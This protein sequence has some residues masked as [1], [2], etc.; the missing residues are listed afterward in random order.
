[1]VKADWPSVWL[2][3]GTIRPLT[4]AIQQMAIPALMCSERAAT[5]QARKAPIENP[6]ASALRIDLW[7]SCEELGRAHVLVGDQAGEGCAQV[8]EIA[9]KGL[10][11][12]VSG[13]SSVRPVKRITAK[14]DVASLRQLITDEAAAEVLPHPLVRGLNALRAIVP[15]HDGLLLADVKSCAMIV[16]D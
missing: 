10:L 14:A 4:V 11:A 1:M 7:A 15:R 13:P 16:Q 6:I 12:L 9:G 8:K 5:C 2:L 3:P